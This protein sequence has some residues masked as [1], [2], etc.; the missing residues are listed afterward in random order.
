MSEQPENI[1]KIEI[2]FKDNYSYDYCVK[3]SRFINKNPDYIK[4]FQD[5]FSHIPL[6]FTHYVKPEKHNLL[7]LFFMIENRIHKLPTEL[8]ELISDFTMYGKEY[9]IDTFPQLSLYVYYYEISKNISIINYEENEI[10]HILNDFYLIPLHYIKERNYNPKECYYT[11]IGLKYCGMGHYI[12]LCYD[13]HFHKYFF[14]YDGGSNGFDQEDTYNSSLTFK[15]HT[16]YEK[17]L[18]TF[19]QA[20]N[21][22]T[23]TIV[24]SST[25]SI[26]DYILN[27][28]LK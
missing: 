9:S 26:Y 28:N 24:D 27:E 5:Y 14:K 16:D 19:S 21:I 18:L 12:T 23:K 22:I 10:D 13:K 17:Y 3:A 7:M 6:L 11:N 1:K 4:I 8:W 2:T 20:N 15:D 25:I